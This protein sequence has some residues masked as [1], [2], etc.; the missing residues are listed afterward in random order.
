MKS[1]GIF[2]RRNV[3]KSSL[4]NLLTGQSISIVSDVP[5]TT[6]DPVKKRMEIH[7][8]GPVEIIDTAGL[9]DTG[10]L[11]AKRVNSTVKVISR[12]D[13]A[14]LMF[15]GNLFAKE[16]RDAMK[17]L[18]EADLPVII[19]HNQSDIVP[20]DAAVAGELA[21]EYD[22]D[23]LEFSCCLIDQDEEKELTENLLALIGR[24]LEQNAFDERSILD[25]LA[26]RSDC[27]ILVCP[28]D[29]EAPAG[30]LILPEVMSI[31]DAI[32]RHALPVV[33]QPEELATAVARNP[34]VK[35]V[36][37]D[38]Q[39]FGQVSDIL[40]EKIPLTSF[41]ILMARSRGSFKEY[42]DGIGQIDKLKDGDTVLM[43]ESCTHHPNCEDIG[44]VQIPRKLMQFTGKKLNF[45]FIS[46]LDDLGDLSRFSL[47][48]QCGGCMVTGRQLHNRIKKIVR[49]G[50]PVTNYGMSLAYMAGILKR[51]LKPVFP[52]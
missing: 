12:I 52:D 50:L 41:S 35:L 30:R 22:S 3:G 2:G 25:G 26:G 10:E 14:I 33:V 32:D 18:K 6:T 19:L 4:A 27:I 38:S 29:S 37:T 1:I 47:A 24:C 23:I 16:E 20:L 43:L 21:D 39:A 28:E 48:I 49:A 7:G 5:G 8:T 46:N 45:E 42:V 9:D 40:D 17:L 15:S 51:A 34:D 31:R 11:G 44:H 13:A 36:V